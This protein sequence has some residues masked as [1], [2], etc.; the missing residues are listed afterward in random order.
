MRAFLPALLLG[1]AAAASGCD[2]TESGDPRVTVIGERLAVADPAAGP[3]QA[4][5]AVLLSAVAQGLV[6]FDAAGQI[7]PGLAERWNV[8]DDGLSYIF[9]I[10]PDAEWPDGGRVTAQQVARILRRQIAPGSD[11]PLRDTL[12]AVTDV[13]AMTDR[14]IEVRLSAPRPNL[15]Q[16]MAQPALAIVRSGAGTGP[17]RIAQDREPDQGGDDDP[18][19][20]GLRLEREI[21][22]GEDEDPETEA[23]RLSAAEARVAI[24]SFL[25]RE[26]DLVL[27]GT[28]ADLPFTRV[29]AMPAGALHFDPAIG[30]FGLAP[31]RSGGPVADPDLRRLLA[32]ALDRDALVAALGVPG[33]LSRAT[34]LEP[35]LDD[36][37]DPAAPEWTALPLAERRAALAAA[38]DRLFDGE[39]ERPVLRIALPDGPGADLLLARLRRDWS[40]LGVGAERAQRGATADLRLVDAVAPS[41]SP[42][43]Y[44]RQFR[45]GVAPVCAEEVDALLEAARTASVLPQRS[46]LLAEAARIVETE[47]LFIP[48]TAPIRWSLVAP[49]VVGFAGNRFAVHPLTDL[50]QASGQ[51]R[52]E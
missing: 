46:A 41:S 51:R 35:G 4:G 38:A 37:G 43:W 19:P 52:A 18:R 21:D 2:R 1:L 5:E 27:G 14:V 9:R 3:L 49:A 11:N 44:L 47:Q 22:L 48:I 32:Q 13:V 34:V 17:F 6:R 12:G 26:T 30:L 24:G 36:H 25:R 7:V 28:F 8:T 45:C 39:E 15:L 42:A 23:V 50:F 20:D 33:L 40:V 31:A 10:A 16:L 29:A